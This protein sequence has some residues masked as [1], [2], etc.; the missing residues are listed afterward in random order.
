MEFGEGAD[1][2]AD[3]DKEKEGADG[4]EE[5]GETAFKGEDEKKAEEGFEDGELACEGDGKIDGSLVPEV[6]AN[7]GTKK[8]ENGTAEE[9]ANEFRGGRVELMD[10]KVAF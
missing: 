2:V 9:E 3:G 8:T 6:T 4:F 1:T 10:V 5:S 7:P